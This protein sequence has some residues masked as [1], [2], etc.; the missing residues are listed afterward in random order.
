[1]V[2]APLSMHPTSSRQ[3]ADALSAALIRTLQT[4]LL[5]LHQA[6]L[7]GVLASHQAHCSLLASVQR[8]CVACTVLSALLAGL[9]EQAISDSA[10]LAEQPDGACISCLLRLAVSASKLSAA[11]PTI[12]VSTVYCADVLGC[13]GQCKGCAAV[14]PALN[15]GHMIPYCCLVYLKVSACLELLA[16]A[17]R[18]ASASSTSVAAAVK[19]ASHVYQLS[20]AKCHGLQACCS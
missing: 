9:C 11:R 20:S 18:A 3:Q 8:F 13:T 19:A 17:H 7:C 5:T 12:N 14:P 4:S 10:Q 2:T 1:M 6:V 16:W 15:I